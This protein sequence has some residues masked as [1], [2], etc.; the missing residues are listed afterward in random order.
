LY[1][2]YS[3]GRE[4]AQ[5]LLTLQKVQCLGAITLIRNNWLNFKIKGKVFQSTFHFFCDNKKNKRHSGRE[6]TEPSIIFIVRDIPTRKGAI[7]AEGNVVK[8]VMSRKIIVYVHC[9]QKTDA[10]TT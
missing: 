9:S 7:G 5:Q 10:R 3:W 2:D 8:Q 1:V 4:K 6:N